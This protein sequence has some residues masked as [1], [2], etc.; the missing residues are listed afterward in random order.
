MDS[1]FIQ[2]TDANSF[3]GLGTI[4]LAFATAGGVIIT[5][6]MLIATVRQNHDTKYLEFIK[7]VDTEI[8][9]QLEKETKLANRDE[10]IIYAYNYI[11]ICDRI[12][13]L[14]NRGII[15]K[16]MIN[17]YQDFFCYAATMMWWYTTIYTEDVYSIKHSWPS[18]LDWISDH[19]IPYPIMHLPKQMQSELANDKK[20]VDEYTIRND[21]MSKKPK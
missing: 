16:N 8:T 4:I 9:E 18:M 3:V 15:S 1:T 17:Y 19:I 7:D 21:L 10:C 14:I 20:Q 12:L 2:I 5:A 11:D 13:F 6:L